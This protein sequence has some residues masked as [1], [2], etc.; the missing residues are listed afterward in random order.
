M[1]S[2]AE[3]LRDRTPAFVG[4]YATEP[5]VDWALV[6]GRFTDPFFGQTIDRAMAHPFNEVFACRTGLHALR[7]VHAAAPGLA[8]AGFI[9]HLSR[10]GSTLVAQMLAAREAARVLSEPQPVDAVIRR[11]VAPGA[12]GDGRLLCEM[13]S[14]LGR[15]SPGER[16]YYIKF[17]AWHVLALPVIRAAFP[18][19]PRVFIFREPRAILASQERIRGAELIPG[20]VDS[21]Y[22]GLTA[23]EA[24]RMETDEYGARMLLAIARAALHDAESERT[25]FVDYDELPDAVEARV[26]PFFGV[27]VD[28]ADRDRMRRTS[29]RDT[30]ADVVSAAPRAGAASS[31]ARIDALAARFLDEAYAALKRAAAAR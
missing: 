13:V 28:D 7:E 27:D 24:V 3:R 29:L 10:C 19:V 18:D 14:V 16:E 11:S 1:T 30:K 6:D 31:N 4:R 23:E 25:L 15:P 5:R 21:A 8:P 17:A 2:I 12:S 26:L 22:A 9:F 20:D